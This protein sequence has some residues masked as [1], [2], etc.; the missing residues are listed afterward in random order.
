MSSEYLVLAC[1]TSAHI[2]GRRE[3]LTDVVQ[4]ELDDK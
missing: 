4:G 2:Y 3:E 1:H